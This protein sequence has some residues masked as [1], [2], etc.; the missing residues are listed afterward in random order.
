MGRYN[1]NKRILLNELHFTS[2]NRLF[3]LFFHINLYIF[4]FEWFFYLSFLFIVAGAI[5]LSSQAEIGDFD[6]VVIGQ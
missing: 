5:D 1:R 3:L 2:K 6:D 4:P